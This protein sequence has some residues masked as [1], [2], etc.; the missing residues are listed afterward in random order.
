[1]A[2]HVKAASSEVELRALNQ[3]KSRD[4]STQLASLRANLLKITATRIQFLSRDIYPT[5][6][7]E[8]REKRVSTCLVSVL[9]T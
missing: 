6:L 3:T 9:S 5:T 4:F 1:M 8:E 2:V 7:D